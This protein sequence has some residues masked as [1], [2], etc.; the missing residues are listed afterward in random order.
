MRL[1]T[2]NL[3]FKPAE[4]LALRRLRRILAD[5]TLEA[6][7]AQSTEAANRLRRLAWL[8]LFFRV[9]MGAITSLGTSGM[10]RSSVV[11]THLIPYIF[12]RIRSSFFWESKEAAMET[13]LDCRSSPIGANFMGENDPR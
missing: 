7:Q 12:S 11:Q 10:A 1:R 2:V 13:G 9:P 5:R 6:L 4:N 8:R 3:A